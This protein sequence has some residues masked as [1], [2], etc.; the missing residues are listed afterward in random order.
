MQLALLQVCGVILIASRSFSAEAI[1]LAYSIEMKSN[2]SM[3]A[4]EEAEFVLFAREVERTVW[5][6]CDNDPHR[7]LHFTHVAAV[8]EILRRGGAFKMSSAL[9]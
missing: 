6:D 8:P 3:V 1:P 9:F 7:V 5:V 2:N 4:S